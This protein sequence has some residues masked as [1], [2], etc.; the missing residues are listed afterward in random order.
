MPRPWCS[1]ENEPLKNLIARIP[2]SKHKNLRKALVDADLTISEWT[3]LQ[4]ALYL[5]NWHTR[6]VHYLE[7]L[8]ECAD[9]GFITLGDEEVG[10]INNL[11][12]KVKK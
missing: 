6:A 1:L 8:K 11:L 2:E 12:S 5:C 4:I 3:E 10:E 9:E 7:T